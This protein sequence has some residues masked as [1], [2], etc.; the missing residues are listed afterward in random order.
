MGVNGGWEPIHQF[1][2]LKRPVAV[3]SD[4]IG[5]VDANQA[6][7]AVFASKFEAETCFVKPFDL[8]LAKYI[9]NQ[10]VQNVS[11]TTG[12]EKGNTIWV[13]D[14]PERELKKLNREEVKPEKRARILNKATRL[15]FLSRRHGRQKMATRLLKNNVSINNEEMHQ[16]MDAVMRLMAS[17]ND[18]VYQASGEAD[19]AINYLSFY[20]PKSV[21]ISNDSDYLL[22]SNAIALIKLTPFKTR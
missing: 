7:C 13:W 16:L 11:S 21:I 6:F 14:G 17:D 8:E 9:S 22:F 10:M 4:E 20:F 5:L 1:P 18:N 12:A 19:F 15:L 3:A 2:A